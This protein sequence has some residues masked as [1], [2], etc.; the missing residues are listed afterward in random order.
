[1]AE[2]ETS[3][4]SRLFSRQVEQLNEELG[5]RLDLF[6]LHAVNPSEVL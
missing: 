2:P 1:M 3:D 4:E 5:L 6:R